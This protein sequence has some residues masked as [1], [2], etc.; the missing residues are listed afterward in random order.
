MKG[1]KRGTE[2]GMEGTRRRTEGTMGAKRKKG[3]KDL[4][5]A[6]AI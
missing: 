4:K 2:R 1:T 3:T 6:K 5:A